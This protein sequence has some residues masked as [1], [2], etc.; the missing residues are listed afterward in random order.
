MNKKG[1]INSKFKVFLT[2]LRALDEQSDEDLSILIDQKSSFTHIQ[3]LKKI[4]LDKY[5]IEENLNWTPFI[6]TE[7]DQLLVDLLSYFSKNIASLDL[8]SFTK[9]CNILNDRRIL[10]LNDLIQITYVL[11]EVFIKNDALYK[12]VARLLKKNLIN[13]LISYFTSEIFE[14]EYSNGSNFHYLFISIV[15]MLRNLSEDPNYLLLFS[16]TQ[17]TNLSGKPLFH[18]RLENKLEK[19]NSICKHGGYEKELDEFLFNLNQKSLEKCVEYFK[20]FETKPSEIFESYD[21][22]KDFLYLF[23]LVQMR[24]FRDYD[25]FSKNQFDVFI[26]KVYAHIYKIKNEIIIDESIEIQRKYPSINAEP[27]ERTISIFIYLLTITNYFKI[28]SHLSIKQIMYYYVKFL[29]DE[30]FIKKLKHISEDSIIDILFFLQKVSIHLDYSKKDCDSLIGA[31]IKFLNKH[32]NTSEEIFISHWIICYTCDDR[33]EKN[34]NKVVNLFSSLFTGGDTK[35]AQLEITLSSKIELLIRCA[36]NHCMHQEIYEQF[37]KNIK[38]IIFINEVVEVEERLQSL[39]LLTLLCL[40]EKIVEQVKLD[41]KLCKYISNLTNNPNPRIS[42]MS[43][44]IE[45]SLNGRKQ[46]KSTKTDITDK[47]QIFISSSRAPRTLLFR[48]EN[49]LKDFDFKV[50]FSSL[51]F[52]N[53]KNAIEKSNYILVCINEKFRRS[54]RTQFE[55]RFAK[56]LSKTIIPISIQEGFEDAV[57]GWIGSVLNRIRIINFTK[58]DFDEVVNSMLIDYL[59]APTRKGSLDS[60]ETVDSIE[61]VD[62]LEL[63]E[64]DD[65]F[66]TKSLTKD[67][68][69]TLEGNDTKKSELTQNI[70]NDPQKTDSSNQ[71]KPLVKE[72]DEKMV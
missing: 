29:E 67:T 5:F 6:E 2:S 46:I 3:N 57:E 45:W 44:I 38:P 60:L 19:F 66:K 37:V 36:S 12:F 7:F 20:E 13:V 15:R 17:D 11:S 59:N 69:Q 28:D 30:N 58:K 39:K 35:F 33:I 49:I 32:E 42:F 18:I 31:L 24:S 10:I 71:N 9:N 48:L 21:A 53:V 47:K 68:H 52:D 22:Y 63:E 70:E 51:D 27:C 14:M 61:T 40:N 1:L 23:R 50:V 41:D 26:P 65:T 34:K 16:S 64:L 8:G 54:E 56:S 72:W 25:L 62:S 55:L 4:M 43:K